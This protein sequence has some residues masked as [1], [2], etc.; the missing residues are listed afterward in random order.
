MAKT[1]AIIG[2]LDT[3]GP[4][5][6]FLKAEIERRGCRTLVINV[7]VLGTPHFQPDVSAEDVALAGGA[8][9]SDLAA[10]HDRGRAM[11]VMNRGIV[12]VLK[13][14]FQEARFDGVISMG[15]GGG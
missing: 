1:V 6:A 14:L 7:G 10:A 15:G 12:Q 13:Q 4:E 3:K 5:F 2:A 11:A 8:T 9:L